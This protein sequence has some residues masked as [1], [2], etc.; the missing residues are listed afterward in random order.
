MDSALLAFLSHSKASGAVADAPLCAAL[1]LGCVK[2]GRLGDASSVTDYLAQRGA[3]VSLK[4]Y[5]AMLQALP[6]RTPAA[7]ALSFCDAL[8]PRVAWRDA[9]GY[10]HFRH[11]SRLLVAEFL[12]EAEQALERVAQRPPDALAAAGQALL[13]LRAAELPKGGQLA[14]QSA[15]PG[16]DVVAAAKDA[17]T[18]GDTVL[19]SPMQDAS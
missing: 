10:G 15:R 13:H 17:F 11:F 8:E 2:G 12:A 18:K 16:V 1:L 9:A 5:A 6:C 7:A 3:T 4:D 19:I 14:L